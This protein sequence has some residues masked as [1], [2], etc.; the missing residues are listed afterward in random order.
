MKHIF[1]LALLALA[2]VASAQMPVPATTAGAPPAT[3][4]NDLSGTAISACGKITSPGNYYLTT[5]L[6]CPGTA[7]LVS[8]PGIHLNLNGHTIV[9]GTAGGALGSI[10]GIENDACWDTDQK[11]VTIPCDNSGAGI[12]IEIYNG[13]IVQSTHAPAFSHALYFGQNENTNQLINIH[14]LTITVQQTGSSGF[15]ST[16]QGGQILIEHNTIYDNVRSINRPGQSDQGARAQYQG[17][18]IHVDNSKQMVA[19]DQIAYNK[20]VGSPQGGIRDTSTGAQI[21]QNDISMNALYANDF[22]V[23]VPGTNERVY[24]NNCHPINGRGI[25]IDSEG[26]YAYNNLIAVTEAPVNREYGGCE[27]GGAYGVQVEDDI[28]HAGNVEV[29][30]NTATVNTGQ[31]GGAPFRITSWQAGE[32]AMVANNHWVVNQTPGAN[33]YGG[34]LYSFDN[35]NVS[36]VTFGQGG[37]SD[38]LQTNG[39]ACVYVDWNGAQN[40][41]MSIPNCR[42]PYALALNSGPG[43]YTTFKISNAPSSQTYCTQWAQALG[44][45][46]GATIKCPK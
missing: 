3:T 21:Y 31:C 16:F 41:T 7:L 34:F 24:S 42:A 18:A 14:N 37:A 11:P 13:S 40:I 2:S 30:G 10:Y 23:D 32:P 45:V 36:A 20:I 4:S 28:Q 15:F 26:S 38:A 17:E 12:G 29:Y 6:T 22:C 27:G 33:Q 5:N 9:Y 8:G 46:D 19:P 39:P 43:Y 1:T 44:T 25:H 35:S